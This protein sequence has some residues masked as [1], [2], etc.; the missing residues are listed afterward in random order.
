MTK[1]NQTHFQKSR[2]EASLLQNDAS[3]CRCSAVSV[4]ERGPWAGL[5][6]TYWEL[7]GQQY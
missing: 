3:S 7:M 4:A 5:T 6:H 1:K 2:A